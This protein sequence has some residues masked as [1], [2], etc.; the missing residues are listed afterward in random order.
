MTNE[1]TVLITGVTGKQGGAVARFLAGKGLGLRGLTRKPDGAKAR[2]VAETGVE[3]VQGDLDDNESLKRALNGVWGVFSVQNT[4]EAGV[5]KEEEQGKRLARLAREAG[6][7]HFV[8]TSVASAQKATGIPHFDNKARIENEV[9]GL[10]FPSYVIM[11]PAYFMENLL[12]PMTLQGSQLVAAISP[13]RPLQM[14]AVSDIG[15]IG[16]EAFLRSTELAGREIELAGDSVTMRH[17]AGILGKALR[18]SLSYTQL[19]IEVVHQQ[20]EDMARMFEWFEKVGYDVDVA[21]LDAEFGSMIRLEH[22]VKTL[23]R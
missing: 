22:W 21:R 8:Y 18:R 4:W 11:R 14:V 1:K 7:Q 15:R 16:S 13:D 23:N 12:G 10:G 3:I 5:K 17:A 20:S 6:V 19:P 9:K 2:K